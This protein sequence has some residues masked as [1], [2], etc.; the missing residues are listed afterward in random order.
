MRNYGL[1]SR[2]PWPR[3][4]CRIGVNS[5]VNAFFMMCKDI[6]CN[7][8]GRRWEHSSEAVEW[9]PR[10]TVFRLLFSSSE[11]DL[12]EAEEGP[13]G[14]PVERKQCADPGEPR[15][16][17]D[18]AFHPQMGDRSMEGRVGAEGSGLRWIQ[19]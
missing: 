19:E 17:E 4:G 8:C 7:N 13:I 14:I 16:E 15:K 3:T 1:D 5:N 10:Q 9:F 2:R 6:P 11:K 12:G 18:K